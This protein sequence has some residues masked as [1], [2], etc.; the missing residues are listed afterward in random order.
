MIAATGSDAYEPGLWA[1]LS[2]AAYDRMRRRLGYR[3]L[4][5]VVTPMDALSYKG[6]SSL[7]E[8]YTS[9]FIEPEELEP[10]AE[11]EWNDLSARFVAECRERGDLCYGAFEGERLVS[12][13]FYSRKPVPIDD[14]L[15]VHFDTRFVYVYKSFTVPSERGRKLHGLLMNRAIR[16]IHDESGCAGL[17][18]YL[19][20]ANPSSERSGARL[21]HRRFGTIR[22]LR[23]RGLTW[24]FHGPGCARYGFRV[25]AR[26]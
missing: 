20:P 7:P 16:A 17:I 6:S 18:A 12:Y 13:S 3:K 15:T 25:T 11:A 2:E 1:R 10:F 5:G 21:G 19:E 9:R 24:T 8:G 23:F 4:I 14:E 26:K 22:V